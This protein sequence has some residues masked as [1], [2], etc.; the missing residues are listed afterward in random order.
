MAS[1][2][3]VIAGTTLSPAHLLSLG[4]FIF[5]MDTMAYSDLVRRTTWRHGSTERFMARPASQFLGPG[6]DSITLSGRL[7][8]EV[9]GQFA[10]IE[11]IKAMADTGEDYPLVDGLGRVLGHYRIVGLEE[12]QVAIMGG[13]LPRG[14]DFNLDLERAD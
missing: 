10:A 1:L 6:E 3:S 2:P 12:R 5:G 13:G 4:M 9:A 14:V 7:M 8:P 11:V